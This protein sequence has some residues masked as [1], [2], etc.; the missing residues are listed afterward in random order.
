MKS[1]GRFSQADVQR[2]LKGAKAA[3]LEPDE[4]FIDPDGAIRVRMRRPEASAG[5]DTPRD[6]RAEIARHF[7]NAKT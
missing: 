5:G 7:G 6:V 3:G 1:R 4:V 2:A